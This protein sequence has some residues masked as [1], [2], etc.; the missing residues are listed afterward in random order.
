MTGVPERIDL[1]CER[2]MQ[3]AFVSIKERGADTNSL[4]RR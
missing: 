2:V 3:V 4:A 1:E